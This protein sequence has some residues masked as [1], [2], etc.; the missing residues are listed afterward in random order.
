MRVVIV[1]APCTFLAACAC[2]ITVPDPGDLDGGGGG[3]AAT[4]GGPGQRCCD[5]SRGA[6]AGPLTT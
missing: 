3:G 6:A 1:L 5:G 2:N 4:G